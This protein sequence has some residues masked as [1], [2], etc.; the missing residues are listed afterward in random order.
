M[1]VRRLILHLFDCVARAIRQWSR[2]SADLSVAASNVWA[3][4][5]V[6]DGEF[7]NE[8]RQEQGEISH[9]NNLSGGLCRHGW[10]RVSCRLWHHVGIVSNGETRTSSSVT[11]LIH[12][13]ISLRN[14]FSTKHSIQHDRSTVFKPIKSMVIIDSPT[15]R[16]LLED[17]YPN[18]PSSKD[19]L[20]PSPFV[21]SSAH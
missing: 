18:L 9:G 7:S 20:V 19:R 16:N 21:Y 14:L 13:S 3:E 10:S 11:L 4:Q 1:N 15:H 12:F 5:R 6:L 17:T 2:L 8:Y